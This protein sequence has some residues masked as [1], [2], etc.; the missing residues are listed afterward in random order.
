MKR[1]ISIFL[2]LA[3]VLTLTAAPAQVEE[4]AAELAE[5]YGV[6]TYEI[7]DDN[8]ITITDCDRSATEVTI[9]A[10]IDG[11][12][13]TSIG[14]SAFSFCSITSVTI[15]DG[16][17]RIGD[18]A[19][20]F[21]DS[22]VTVTIPNSVTSIGERAFQ[23]CSNLAN[24]SIPNGVTEIGLMSFLKCR[25][26]TS[27]IIPDSVT[28]IGNLAF[29][30]CD[31]LTSI[32]IPNSLI[33]IGE[34]AF[35]YCISLPSIEIPDSVT[36]IWSGAF[37]E[38][39]KL[40][41]NVDSNNENYSS[42]DG[43]LFNKD[44]TGLIAYPKDVISPSY[45]IPIG[46]KSIGDSAFSLCRN[47]ISV[48]IPNSVTYI[49][50]NAFECCSSLASITIPNGITIIEEATFYNCSNLTSVTIPN[51]VTS[52]GDS[53]F[54][55][56]I[57]LT[58]VTIPNS[59]TSIES[60]AFQ[61]CSNLSNVIIPD[62]VTSIGDSAFF[63]CASLTSITIPDS[64]ANIGEGA[65]SGCINLT[66]VY[67]AGTESQWNQI[68]IDSYNEPLLSANIHFAND[69]ADVKI[70][71]AVED[72][73]ARKISADFQNAS[74]AAKTFDAICAVYDERG[75]L[76]TY[77]DVTVTVAS[78]EMRK[79]EFFLNE[80]GWDSYK[81]FAWDELGSMRPLAFAES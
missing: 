17:T 1:L 42:I 48:T 45:T 34:G 2:V 23:S 24:I 7:N 51:S 33:S 61:Y 18:S 36:N 13:V 6:L 11:R 66:D 75:A 46:V 71:G 64:V 38:C 32:T 28:S 15:P 31:N 62:S 67:Y 25:S 50:Y 27:V 37:S 26:L 76:I 41:I 58:S 56:C 35:T 57:S 68:A 70:G 3:T 30:Y 44:A 43:V 63:R 77:D 14:D 60:G 47:L 74:G 73:T 21:C 40:N 9:P 8:T 78:G 52:I 20:S 12:S 39:G 59:V 80:S 5:T 16:V 69:D 79:I 29:A 10:E 19:F 4:E 54:T 49:G 22:L 55:G 81:L 53:S 72:K 65:F